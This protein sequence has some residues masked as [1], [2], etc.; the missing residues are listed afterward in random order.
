MRFFWNHN[1]K[2]LQTILLGHYIPQVEQK[3]TFDWGSMFAKR[4]SIHCKCL[5]LHCCNAIKTL[6][7]FFFYNPTKRLEDS[8]LWELWKAPP[9]PPLICCSSAPSSRCARPIILVEICCPDELIIRGTKSSFPH[10]MRRFNDQ[11]R[12]RE[13]DD[14]KRWLVCVRTMWR[15]LVQACFR[16]RGVI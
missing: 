5:C 10:S 14:S 1:K 3:K 15:S 11:S 9:M 2:K 7:R 16:K 4:Q 6:K 12:K 8:H 13:A